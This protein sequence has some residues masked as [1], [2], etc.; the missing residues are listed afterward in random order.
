MIESKDKTTKTNDLS[1]LSK[2]TW[3]KIY[4]QK[5]IISLYIINK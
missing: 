1:K 4:M 3:Y 5:S 2:T